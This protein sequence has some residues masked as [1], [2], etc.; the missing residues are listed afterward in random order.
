MMRLKKAYLKE[1]SIKLESGNE[2]SVRKKWADHLAEE[3]TITDDFLETLSV[4]GN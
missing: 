2:R 3:E 1:E 4:Y